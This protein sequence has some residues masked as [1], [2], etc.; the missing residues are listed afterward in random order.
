PLEAARKA[1]SL[2]MM[3]AFVSHRDLNQLINRSVDVENLQFAI[4]QGMSNNR[5]KRLDISDARELIGYEPQDD[6]T[7]ENPA[8]KDLRLGE[9]LSSHNV[10]D[11]GKSGIREELNAL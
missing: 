11:G 3:D 5:F 4:F 10:T 7:A 1:D 9:Q 2:G 6:F 8:V